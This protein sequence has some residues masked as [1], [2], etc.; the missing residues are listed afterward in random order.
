MSEMKEKF[1]NIRGTGDDQPIACI[2]ETI[3]DTNTMRFDLRIS[4]PFAPWVG[5][6]TCTDH[7]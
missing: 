1:M 6:I 7:V 5:G 4:D 3:C 2:E